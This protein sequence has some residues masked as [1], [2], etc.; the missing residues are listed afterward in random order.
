[1]QGYAR[2]ITTPRVDGAVFIIHFKTPRIE[3]VQGYAWEI[4]T[5]EVGCGLHGV[6][7]AR[8][9]VLNGITNGVDTTEW[10]PQTDSHTPASFSA[11]D[12][13]GKADCKAALQ[14]ELG[15]EVNHEVGASTRPGSLQY[16][17]NV[18]PSAR[19]LLCLYY[20]KE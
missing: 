2:E 16:T 8:Q 17:P 9:H 7:Q 3:D 13:R 18:C 20:Y 10:D 5:P 11:A 12:L 19:Q 4:T 15:F 1:M 14:A 6:L